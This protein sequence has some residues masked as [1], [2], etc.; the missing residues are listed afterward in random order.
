MEPDEGDQNCCA[1]D[2]VM[3]L[4]F[5]LDFSVQALVAGFWL[6]VGPVQ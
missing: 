3:V 1:A 6:L 2:M 5:Q 4:M